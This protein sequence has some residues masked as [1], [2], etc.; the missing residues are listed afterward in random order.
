MIEHETAERL[1]EHP[2][3]TALPPTKAH[4]E[5]GADKNPRPFC[6]HSLFHRVR[7]V[8]SRSQYATRVVIRRDHA[9]ASGGRCVVHGLTRK[10]HFKGTNVAEFPV[11]GDSPG[12]VGLGSMR[13]RRT[14]KRT[15]LV[16]TASDCPCTTHCREANCLHMVIAVRIEAKKDC[17]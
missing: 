8:L 15:L 5:R 2:S 9:N 17:R 7:L 13:W 6:R 12:N 4:S 3:I 11:S 10:S 1:M 14:T 16:V